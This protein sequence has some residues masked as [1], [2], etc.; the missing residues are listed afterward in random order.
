MTRDGSEK[1]NV[2]LRWWLIAK[3]DNGRW[4]FLTM[5]GGGEETL[6]VFGHEEEA[7]MFLHLSG[8]SDD[9]WRVRE[10]S[11]GEIVSVLYGPCSGAKGVALD[12]IPGMVSEGT[13]GFV[14]LERECFL[15]RLLRDP[16]EISANYQCR[17]PG[18]QERLSLFPHLKD[19]I[20]GR[21]GF[22][23]RS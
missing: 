14:R 5:H 3:N 6:A 18:L 17:K 8:K 21:N 20:P 13:V 16:Q 2:R 19:K 7:K 15:R 23:H 9:G 10:S 1:K 22:G 4:E 12:P 11:T